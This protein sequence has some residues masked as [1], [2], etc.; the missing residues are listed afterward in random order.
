MAH[1]N[2]LEFPCQGWLGAPGSCSERGL[3]PVNIYLQLA[4]AYGPQGWWPLQSR[5]SRP[6]YDQLSAVKDHRVVILDDNLVSVGFVVHLNYKNPH[7]SPFEEFQKFKGHPAISP[8][9]TVIR[10][11]EFWTKRGRTAAEELVN[12]RLVPKIV[13]A[14]APVS[15][16][17]W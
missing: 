7:L 17:N 5:C 14:P 8:L 10:E 15:M 3:D 6:G 1:Q 2:P 11:A 9:F 12:T 4:E 13:T 16:A